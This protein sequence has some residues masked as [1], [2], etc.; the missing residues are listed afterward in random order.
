MIKEKIRA[1]V[2]ENTLILK[3]VIAQ[4][5][6]FTVALCSISSSLKTKCSI[7]CKTSVSESIIYAFWDTLAFGS[8][9]IAIKAIFESFI[10]NEKIRLA[11]V[12]KD[13]KFKSSHRSEILIYYQKRFLEAPA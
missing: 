4:K 7:L 8:L 12:V 13:P 10:I 1:F 11:F 9:F 5:F 3:V 6:W 2:V